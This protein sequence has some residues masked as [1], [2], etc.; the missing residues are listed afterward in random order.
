MAPA[1]PLPYTP[2]Y[3]VINAQPTF[4]AVIKNM[5]IGDYA[6]FFFGG[7][8]GAAW[9]FAAGTCAFLPFL[10]LSSNPPPFPL[11]QWK[12]TETTFLTTRN[13]HA[14]SRFH[15]PSAF[16]GKPVRRAGF[17]YMGAT[18]AS[19]CA[20]ASLRSSYHRLTGQ[21]PNREEC[22]IKGIPYNPPP[23]F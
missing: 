16:A 19:L 2:P 10:P 9:G 20:L 4:F 3:P 18:T 1:P 11:W 5:G 14:D 12:K 22:Y 8:L 17:W 15:A 6:R 23:G 13:A 7:A 21:R